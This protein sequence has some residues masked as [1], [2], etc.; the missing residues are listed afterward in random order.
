MFEGNW[1]KLLSL[2]ALT[3]ISLKINK[4]KLYGKKSNKPKTDSRKKIPKTT[5]N[6]IFMITNGNWKR[7][8][9]FLLQHGLFLGSC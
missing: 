1:V 8:L 9:Y 4:F 3:G 5:E 2:L 6:W 7:A